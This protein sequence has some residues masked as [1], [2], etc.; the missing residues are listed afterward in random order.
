MRGGTLL[1]CTCGT[2]NPVEAKFC[3][4]CGQPLQRSC[5]AC[6]VEVPADAKFCGECGTPLDA[7]SPDLRSQTPRHLAEQ[8][9]STRAAIEGERKQVT[10]LFCDVRESMRHAERLDAEEWRQ[11]MSSFLDVLSEGVHRFEGIVNQ[12]TGDGMM[13]LFGAP[14]AHEDHAATGVPCRTA[15]R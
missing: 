1:Q 7:S 8:I 3:A 2:D 10:V 6:R 12:F 4:E 15:P 9:L 13:A 14:I 11:I 5:P